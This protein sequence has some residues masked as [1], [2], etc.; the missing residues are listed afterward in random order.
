MW[1]VVL[2][3]DWVA[4]VGKWWFDD[5]LECH[6]GGLGWVTQQIWLSYI[7]NQQATTTIVGGYDFVTFMTNPPHP[8]NFHH[9]NILAKANKKCSAESFVNKFLMFSAIPFISW[10]F[11]RE[12]RAGSF[13]IDF[14]MYAPTTKCR[15]YTAISFIF[16][17]SW[18]VAQV[19]TPTTRRIIPPPQ[20][21]SFPLL[22]QLFSYTRLLSTF[23]LKSHSNLS[24]K[25]R[26]FLRKKS[27]FLTTHKRYFSRVEGMRGETVMFAKAFVLLGKQNTSIDWNR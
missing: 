8:P 1:S 13:Y 22:C 20:L 18:S 2:C 24:W 9:R 11:N 10:G 6:Q 23:G 15:C 21:R 17:L 25:F 3:V 4:G 14:S 7:T 26:H 12:R 19:A 5:R 16:S 27:A